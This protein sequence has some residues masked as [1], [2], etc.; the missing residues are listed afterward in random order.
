[1]S[2]T[3]QTVLFCLLG[4]SVAVSVARLHKPVAGRLDGLDF[5]QLLPDW[6]F[7]APEPNR[8][9]YHLL[10]RHRTGSEAPGA[11]QVL[12]NSR[13][14]TLRPHLLDPHRRLRKAMVDVSAS[15]IV[16]SEERRRESAEQLRPTLSTSM[17]YL[18]LLSLATAKRLAG[19]E[20]Q[21]AV[22]ATRDEEDDNGEV[23]MLSDFHP[24]HS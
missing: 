5:L 14:H 7:F 23:V 3:L 24:A 21:F 11:W 9:D 6:K 13:K 22:V 10:A 1:M 18:L 16:I 20:I 17:T 4:L 8:S 2:Y 12:E 15:Y 19:E